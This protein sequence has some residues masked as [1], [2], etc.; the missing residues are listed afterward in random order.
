M[1]AQQNVYLEV[2]SVS[3]L[4]RVSALQVQGLKRFVDTLCGKNCRIP[5]ELSDY[6]HFCADST[7][8]TAEV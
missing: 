3:L 8:P 5:L 6:S 1:V 7:I 2:R 4:F